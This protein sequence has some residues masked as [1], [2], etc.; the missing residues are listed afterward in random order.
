MSFLNN[1]ARKGISILFTFIL[2][3]LTGCT[4]EFWDD[5][6]AEDDRRS[7]GSSES[8]L[9]YDVALDGYSTRPGDPIGSGDLATAGHS[10]SAPTGSFD[11]EW[12]VGQRTDAV[13]LLVDQG[14]TVSLD[15]GDG[16]V[17]ESDGEVEIP[18][19]AADWDVTADCTS[20][21]TDT[22]DLI[23]GAG[24]WE[25]QIE[26]DLALAAAEDAE[27]RNP[28]AAALAAWAARAIAAGVTCRGVRWLIHRYSDY[29]CPV[30]PTIGCAGML[31]SC[32]LDAS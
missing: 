15:N 8:A 12:T 4:G 3:G 22:I 2:G 9:L 20:G 5:P 11:A 1:T 27:S 16:F 32:A 30:T 31:A 26:Y 21:S 25:E 23:A 10:L 24:D 19:Y 28:A 7:S 29:Y 13:F 18:S 14:C 17:I 6:W